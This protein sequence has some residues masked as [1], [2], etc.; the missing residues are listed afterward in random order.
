[1]LIYIHTLHP[2][3]LSLSSHLSLTLRPSLSHALHYLP[4]CST[5]RRNT[6]C[7]F[8]PYI[9]STWHW[10][11]P[12]LLREE[13]VKD[14]VLLVCTI[15]LVILYPSRVQSTVLGAGIPLNSHSRTALSPRGMD[16]KLSSVLIPVLIIES[17][18]T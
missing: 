14:D 6:D 16:W 10:Y 1:M 12:L 17:L 18:S 13:I 7:E 2:L 3:F 9:F 8:L 11:I 15:P 4:S 5:A